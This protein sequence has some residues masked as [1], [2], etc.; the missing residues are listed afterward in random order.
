GSAGCQP[1]ATESYTTL[2]VSPP[3]TDR[4]AEQ[5]GDLNL[6]WRGYTPTL[7]TLTLVDLG[8]PTDS[9]APQFPG[10]FGDNRTPQFSSAAQVYN[11]SWACNCRTTPITNPPVTVLG[12]TT[13]GGEIIHTPPSGYSIGSGFE[14]LVLYAAASRITL[15]YTRDD[16]VIQGY[17]IHV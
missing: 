16:N 14:V 1:I 12:M 2:S 13:S 17:T 10:F 15:K 3:P 11:W 8:G 9:S 6:G 7:A 5:H 4:P